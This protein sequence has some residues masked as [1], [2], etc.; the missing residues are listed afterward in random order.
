[1]VVIQPISSIGDNVGVGPHSKNKIEV[2]QTSEANRRNRVQT[3]GHLRGHVKDDTH[4]FP[5]PS[6]FLSRQLLSQTKTESAT[7]DHH[8]FKPK[9]SKDAPQP[10]LHGIKAKNRD[11][12][13][14]DCQHLLGST[15]STS[16]NNGLIYFS[17]TPV[18][19]SAAAAAIH[20]APG[21]SHR[22]SH[23]FYNRNTSSFMKTIDHLDPKKRKEKYDKLFNVTNM[24]NN[25][26]SLSAQERLS[27]YYTGKALDFLRQYGKYYHL[28][29]YFLPPST[30]PATSSSATS[31]STDSSIVS[32]SFS[33]STKTHLP[34]IH[35]EV[36]TVF[37]HDEENV[38]NDITSA[39]NSHPSSISST[40][41]I[42]SRQSYS[43][44]IST[45]ITPEIPKSSWHGSQ[46]LEDNGHVIRDFEH[47]TKWNVP[48]V[49]ET[50]NANNNKN[51]RYDFSTIDSNQ[52]ISVSDAMQDYN[53][54]FRYGPGINDRFL[55]IG[56]NRDPWGE[57]DDSNRHHHS[58][59]SHGH[60]TTRSSNAANELEE[61]TNNR[62]D[63]KNVYIYFIGVDNDLP[64]T[65]I[66]SQLPSRDLYSCVFTY[67][68][69]MESPLE[70]QSNLLSAVNTVTKN[71][72]IRCRVPD[73][74]LYHIRS[75]STAHHNSGTSHNSESTT[76][77]GV[78]NGVNNGGTQQ[79]T[80]KHA[81]IHHITFD[82]I[83]TYYVNRT[84][85]IQ[86]SNKMKYNKTREFHEHQ[87][88]LSSISL[89]RGHPLDYRF[90]PYTIQ[91]MIENINDPLL[92]EWIIYNILLGFEHF[93]FY[94]NDPM[95]MTSSWHL[96]HCL[97]K[98]FL[99][100]NIV[101]LVYFP[102][103]HTEHFS[104]IQYAALN[105][106][107]YLFGKRSSH[108]VG[109]WDVDEFFTPA[110][111]LSEEYWGVSKINEN[112]NIVHKKESH[113]KGK[114]HNSNKHHHSNTTQDGEDINIIQN[115]TF[116]PS[117]SPTLS[118]TYH[119]TAH[120]S[121][122]PSSH[123]PNYLQSSLI[124]FV[125]KKL[126]VDPRNPAIMF[127]AIEMDCEPSFV[128]NYYRGG[129]NLL[130]F[131][132]I[133]S[134]IVKKGTKST[135]T[136][137]SDSGSYQE[138][139]NLMKG[140]FSMTLY[141]TRAG[142]HFEEMKVGH[143]KM[144]VNPK[145]LESHL[146]SPHRLNHYY[147]VWTNPAT[148]GSIRHFNRFRHTHGMISQGTFNAEQITHDSSLRKLTLK[149]L[150]ELIGVSIQE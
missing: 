111:V 142:Y 71:N 38:N 80:H 136:A 97:I 146:A 8:R 149:L 74:I 129:N 78:G 47:Y 61:E 137:S 55:T 130:P 35:C 90:F 31:T 132:D 95:I 51:V 139:A 133:Y 63:N 60:S 14:Q 70:I 123:L 112:V 39:T 43:T 121:Q 33:T 148:G 107:V 67:P 16:S 26:L 125:A 45:S 144:L 83:H 115:T 104:K 34:T 20:C 68:M 100:S 120:P 21:T 98:P 28:F 76:T 24:D 10:H 25:E 93:Y 105:A 87:T 50:I 22:I 18:S 92:V 135:T 150:K 62:D 147:V 85:T 9:L 138:L 19:E 113:H 17:N 69:R 59:H 117:L 103:Y 6:Q 86:N 99:E 41:G 42:G 73:E 101:T 57:D 131:T 94:V 29:D 32:S 91:T 88:L 81:L 15:Q 84:I 40:H 11:K 116:H 30:T 127:D 109:Y 79:Q 89:Y 36:P 23:P 96:E 126:A 110:D 13:Q 1:M 145:R 58:T 5:V 119:P 72:R 114:D 44:S 48:R 64:N 49:K 75:S 52:K 2:V 124:H 77:A 82:L 122:P 108:W 134:S 27:R 7:N 46:S 37:Y 54:R 65:D 4:F 3:S 140:R 106:H 56:F 12:Q 102:F 143:G 66:S 118:P 53:N 128:D 141:C